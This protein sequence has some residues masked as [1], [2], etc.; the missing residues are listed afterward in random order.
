MCGSRRPGRAPTWARGSELS[1]Q[2]LDRRGAGGGRL[3]VGELAYGCGDHVRRADGLLADRGL[4]IGQGGSDLAPG[5]ARQHLRA[6]AR[7]ADQVLV[8]EVDERDRARVR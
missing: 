1:L 4:R 3:V 6:V 8:A 5:L 2:L 7:P